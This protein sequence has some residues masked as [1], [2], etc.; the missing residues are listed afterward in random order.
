VE[1]SLKR[2]RTIKKDQVAV[3]PDRCFAGIDG[4][5]GVLSSDVDLVLIACASRFHP[6][7]TEAAV[8]AGKHV[9][10]E[11]P[12]AI[13][14]LGL[15]R[16]RAVCEQAKQKKLSLA[17]GLCYRYS[18]PMRETIKRLHDGAIGEILAIESN[19][20]RGGPYSLIPRNPAWTEMEYQFRN[21]YHFTWL[22]GDDVL[23]SLIHNLDK[24]CWVLKDISPEKIRGLGGRSSM[25]GTVFGDSFDNHSVVYKY[26]NG[27]RVYAYCSTQTGCRSDIS[28]LIHGTK[29]RCDL[30]K[31]RISGAVNW[32]YEG[33][34]GDMYDNEHKELVAAIRTGRRIDNSGYM[35]NSTLVAILG[36]I[37][38][39]TGQEI[40]WEEGLKSDFSFG[41]A[42]CDFNTKPSIKP[43]DKGLYR[44]P[45]PGMTRM[46]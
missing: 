34:S 22:S 13:D 1:G 20:L 30:M 26:A 2:L 23:Q 31:G 38:C 7:Y 24:A 8:A 28:D 39:Y 16:V 11:K 18:P 21:W 41:P 4:Y 37:A 19:Y 6:Q 43:D 32:R 25:F 14:P 29:G 10:V 27:L 46:I 9:F 12:H 40:T 33:P 15:R 3:K 45:I 44:V 35:L 5:K 36:Q 17:S 42:E